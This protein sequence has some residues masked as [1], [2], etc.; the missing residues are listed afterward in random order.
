MDSSRDLVFR[1][2]VRAVMLSPGWKQREPREAALVPH[3]HVN[4]LG[5]S[6]S[7]PVAVLSSGFPEITALDGIHPNPI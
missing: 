1:G 4:G 5:M 6:P 3:E 2:V 7:A